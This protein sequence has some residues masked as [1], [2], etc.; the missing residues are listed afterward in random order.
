MRDESS[1]KNCLRVVHLTTYSL[2][3]LDTVFS[4]CLKTQQMLVVK[5]RP[6]WILASTILQLLTDFTELSITLNSLLQFETSECH[7]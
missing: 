3:C 1:E 6:H 2:Q 4:A 5:K 7:C